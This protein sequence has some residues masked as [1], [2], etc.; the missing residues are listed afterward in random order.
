V[1]E[2]DRVGEKLKRLNVGVAEKRRGRQVPLSNRQIGLIE[3]L[4]IRG[5]LT[6]AVA[7]KL[8]PEV[9]DDT[10]LRDLK[11]LMEKG[12]VVKKGRT[13]GARYLLSQVR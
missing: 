8:L 3:E 6:M 7:R 5:E 2:M 4:E 9:S 12:V 11:D 10:I 13:K 1:E